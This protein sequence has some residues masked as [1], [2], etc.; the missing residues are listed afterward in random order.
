MNS[1]VAR[2]YARAIFDLG[3]EGGNLETLVADIDRFA[4]AYRSSDELRA[5]L[6]DP[7]VALESRR[8]IVRDIAQRLSLGDVA[9][10]SVLFLLDRRRLEALP[11][12]A[13]ELRR[14][15][16]ERKGVVHAEVTVAAPLDASFYTRLQAQLERLTGKRVV[17]E[18]REDPSLL[19]GV[20]TRIGDVVYDGSLRARLDG[21]RTALLP[22]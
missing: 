1:A 2:R 7:L 18:R 17:L 21:L 6:T 14:L 5:A 4:D 3:L 11:D 16:D 8:A 10:S 19:A 13:E 22:N 20:V 12:I 15:G 9:R